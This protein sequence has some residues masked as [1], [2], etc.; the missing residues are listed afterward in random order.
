M[1]KV[2][3]LFLLSLLL[4]GCASTST[5]TS[6][7]QTL[8]GMY[9]AFARGDVPTVLAGLDPDIVWNEA[10]GSAYA[11]GSPYHGPQAVVQGVFM[12]LGNEWNGYQVKPDKF[13]DSGDTVVVLGRYAG[14][15]KATGQQ[16]HA[17]FA[18]VWTFRN[19]K[20]VSFQQY[21]DT[22]QYNR[23]MGLPR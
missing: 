22:A 8:R 21:T 18:H 16:I 4:F 23:V 1:R 15:F 20:A 12:R 6:N 9:D 7:S 11:S 19:G 17:P 14:T 3:P 5:N 10:E 13:I 2:V